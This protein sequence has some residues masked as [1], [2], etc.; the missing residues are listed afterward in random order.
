MSLNN[1]HSQHAHRAFYQARR[2]AQEYQHD[3][4]DTDHL[5]VGILRESGSLGCRVLADLNADARRAALEVRVLHPVADPLVSTPDPT[6]ALR[7]VL[8]L[9]RDESRAFGQRYVGTEHFLL[10]LVRSQDGGAAAL[11]RTLAIA[12]DQVRQRTL[13]LL[14]DAVSELDIEAARRAARLSELSRRVLNAAGQLAGGDSTAAG[15]DHL[16]LVLA[17]ERRSPVGGLLIDCGLDAD[18]LEA[19]LGAFAPGGDL[20]AEV[21]L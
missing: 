12:P 11:F 9:A 13:A 17:R 16:L 8:A 14:D 15:L 5:L 2:L 7:Y 3:A 1:R 19:S 4:V 10:A 18:A 21:V 6:P 20:S